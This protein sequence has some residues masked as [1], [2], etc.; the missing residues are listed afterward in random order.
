MVSADK[1]YLTT[2]RNTIPHFLFFGKIYPN[3]K[4]YDQQ[5]IKIWYIYVRILIFM[6]SLYPDITTPRIV[7]RFFRAYPL[8]QSCQMVI[9]KWLMSILVTFWASTHTQLVFTDF[10]LWTWCK[11]SFY[12]KV[13]EIHENLMDEKVSRICKNK[14]KECVF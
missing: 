1:T 2:P 14:I 5:V 4:F 12:A 13:S 10:F 3:L 11:Y 8:V 7:A 9:G 6:S